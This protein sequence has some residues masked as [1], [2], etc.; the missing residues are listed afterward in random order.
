MSYKSVA[1]S[2]CNVAATTASHAIATAVLSAAMTPAQHSCSSCARG[3][4]RRHW[5][6]S[7]AA[8]AS[9][10]TKLRPMGAI[11]MTYRYVMR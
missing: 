1:Y 11:S 3:Y 9:P 5:Y 7:L 2:A 8:Y 10:A 6:R 4:M